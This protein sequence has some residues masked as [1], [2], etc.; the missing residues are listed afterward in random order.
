MNS[1]FKIELPTN[2]FSEYEISILKEHGEKLNL[3]GKIKTEK[4]EVD[5]SKMDYREISL[6]KTKNRIN[7]LNEIKIYKT[8]K[9][10]QIRLKNWGEFYAILSKANDNEIE[11]LSKILKLKIL[12]P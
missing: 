6:I 5:Y 8:W 9:K 3:G 7:Q 10:Y 1:V 11:T 2:L 4:L 12:L